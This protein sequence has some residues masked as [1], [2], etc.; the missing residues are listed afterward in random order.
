MAVPQLPDLLRRT[1][2]L[3]LSQESFANPPL[4]YERPSLA[5]ANDPPP[6]VSAA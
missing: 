5:P 6:Q 4:P 2:A 1:L 3:T